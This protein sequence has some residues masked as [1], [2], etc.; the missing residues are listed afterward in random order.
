MCIRDRP[1]ID[2]IPLAINSA[3]ICAKLKL[4]QSKHCYASPPVKGMVGY[5]EPKLRAV[6]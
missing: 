6:K 4:T 1:V 3:Y 2:P 5:G